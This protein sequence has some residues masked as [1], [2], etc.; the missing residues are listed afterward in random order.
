MLFRMNWRCSMTFHRPL[1]STQIVVLWTN[2]ESFSD[3]VR[4]LLILEALRSGV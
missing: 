3:E 4:T 1:H 2:V